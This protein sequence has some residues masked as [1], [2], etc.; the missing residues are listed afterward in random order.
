MISQRDFTSKKTLIFISKFLTTSNQVRSPQTQLSF[1]SN[2][3][4]IL[5]EQKNYCA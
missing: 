2:L 5:E 1:V 4:D 3:S